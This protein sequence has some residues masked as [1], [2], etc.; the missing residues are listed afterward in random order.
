MRHSS[1]IR[2]HSAL[3]LVEILVAIGII[4]VLLALLLPA[5]QKIRTAASLIREKNK[6]KQIELAL[7]IYADNHDR[8]SNPRIFRELLP[9]LEQ[10]AYYTIALPRGLNHPH[11][12]IAIPT[13]LNYDDPSLAAFGQG[14]YASYCVNGQVHKEFNSKRIT[15][16]RDGMSNTIEISTHYA[17]I[18]RQETNRFYNAVRFWSALLNVNLLAPSYYDP[19]DWLHVLPP[20]FAN[21]Y[22]GDVVPGSPEAEFLTFQLRPK[23]EDVDIRIPQSP[24]THGLLVGIA[25][26]SVRMLHP[27]ISPRTFWAAVTPN[28]GE[29]LG[30]E[31]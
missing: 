27:N 4:A 31:W 23:I 12:S 5:V 3:S 7:H 8:V 6:V 26:G 25:D 13:Y 11:V 17:Q 24:Y 9:Y 21:P 20:A 29:V 18:R 16:F 10:G 19:N 22:T 1:I 2:K 30:P 15:L 14:A 28:G